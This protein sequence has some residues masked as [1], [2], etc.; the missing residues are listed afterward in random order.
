MAGENPAEPT[1]FPVHYAMPSEGNLSDVLDRQ[2]FAQRQAA[3]RKGR[4]INRNPY[5]GHLTAG[6]NLGAGYP[7]TVTF[8]VAIRRLPAPSIHPRDRRQISRKPGV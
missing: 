1:T 7:L 4:T 2:D 8:G 3:N 6:I 5:C